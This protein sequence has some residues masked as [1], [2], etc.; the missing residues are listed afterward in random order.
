[1]MLIKIRQRFHPLRAKD[2]ALTMTALSAHMV[3]QLW[4]YVTGR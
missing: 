2:L 1:M 3:L 4:L